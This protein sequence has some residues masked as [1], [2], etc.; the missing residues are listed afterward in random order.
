MT[1]SV[2]LYIQIRKKMFEFSVLA[3]YIIIKSHIIS[4]TVEGL[5][6]SDFL[7]K[8]HSVVFSIV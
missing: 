3:S 4:G 5:S 7:N 8:R 6:T 1:A 2:S